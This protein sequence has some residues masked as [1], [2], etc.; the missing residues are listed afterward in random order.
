MNRRII[1]IDDVTMK[2]GKEYAINN[3]SLNLY[4]NRIVG[5]CGPNG[6]GKTTLIKMIV[7]LIRSYDGV[8]RINGEFVS[9]K[10]KAMVSY[11]PDVITLDKNL[12]GQRAAK[13]FSDL[14]SD[15][16]HKRFLELVEKL[17]LPLNKPLSKM[18]KGMKEKFQLAIT[19]SRDAHVYIFDEPIAGVDPASRDSILET[20]IQYYTKDSLLIVSTHL[21][22]DIESILDEVI[23]INE[24][25]IILHENCDDLRAQR[26]MSI[27]EIFREEFRW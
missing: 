26:Q 8:I 18:S 3:V 15:F 19:L 2:Y 11:Q 21:I 12:T 24:G 1:T 16:D 6:A 20:I 7:G 14:Y 13:E 9:Q 10:T 17:K 4:S 27:D 5:L 25:Q 23:F 22:Q